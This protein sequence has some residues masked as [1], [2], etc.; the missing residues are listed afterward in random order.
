MNSSSPLWALLAW[1]PLQRVGYHP[2]TLLKL[3]R[4]GYLNQVA[5]SRR[6]EREAG[7]NVEVIW[8]TGRLA[9]DLKA[10]A[11]FHGDNGPAIHA[12]W[13]QFVVLCRQFGLLI[14]GVVALDGSRFKAGNTRD[15]IFTP[16]AIQGRIEQVEPGIAR[17][18]AAFDTADRRE[19]EVAQMR[20]TRIAER[21]DALRQDAGVA[22]HA[23]RGR[24]C[25]GSA[26][27]PHRSGRAGHGREGQ[28]HGTGG[29]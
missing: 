14:G 9:P 24:G 20:T 28:R 6:F 11:D 18:L 7:R 3:Y 19:D 15:K 16:G 1:C 26:D 8:L 27:L 29:L 17:Y 2:A 4:Y 25:V 10:V 13:A 23:D 5:S 22:G 12:T 21:L